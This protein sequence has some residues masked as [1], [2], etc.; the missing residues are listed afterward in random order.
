MT[1]ERMAL[2]ELLQRSGDG[3]G[4]LKIVA[5]LDCWDFDHP[6]RRYPKASDI[7]STTAE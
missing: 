1:D 7:S 3:P 2:V 6:I 5:F 4:R